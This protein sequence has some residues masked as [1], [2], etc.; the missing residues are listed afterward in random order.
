MGKDKW[1]Q[2]DKKFLSE[3]ELQQFCKPSNKAP[4]H[5]KK[6]R[7]TTGKHRKTV[8]TSLEEVAAIRGGVLSSM[9]DF[10][11][12]LCTFLSSYFC[13]E[14]DTEFCEKVLSQDFFTTYQKIK[15]F[16]RIGYHK[17]EKYKGK[18]NGLSGTMLK[19]N[20]LRNLVAHGIQFG[21]L[22]PKLGFP[23]SGESTHF[24]NDLAQRFKNAFYQVHHSLYFLRN[25]LYNE[26]VLRKNMKRN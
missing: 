15:L 13:E 23:F 18:Y 8:E 21:F 11:N 9:I 24:N 25:D 12:L 6:I 2:L 22:E 20:E 7:N 4:E 3:E 14:K 19:L 26:S 17:K 1:T 10:E 16:Q 5:R